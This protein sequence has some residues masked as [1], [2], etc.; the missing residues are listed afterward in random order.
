[1][2]ELKGVSMAERDRFW[3]LYEDSQSWK[4]QWEDIEEP[5]KKVY[6]KCARNKQIEHAAKVVVVHRW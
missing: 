5:W 6:V 2:D 1:M 3:G 4:D